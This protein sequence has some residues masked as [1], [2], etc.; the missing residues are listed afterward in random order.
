M[1]LLRPSLRLILGIFAA[2]TSLTA[3]SPAAEEPPNK[4]TITVRAVRPD[5]E[6][7]AV[8]HLFRGSRAANP[9]AALTAWKRASVE[10]KRLGKVVDAVIALLNPRMLREY[11]VLD[12]AEVAISFIPGSTRWDWR[13]RFPHDDGTLGVVGPTADLSGGRIEPAIGEYRVDRFPG[14]TLVLLARGPAGLFAAG[15]REQLEAALAVA[16]VP[17]TTPPVDS[18]WLIQIDPTARDTW[19]SLTGQR[20]A[21]AAQ[22]TGCQGVSGQVQ[23]LPTTLVATLTGQFA[24]N[25]PIVPSIDSAWLDPIPTRGPLAAFSLRVDPSAGA[26]SRV[27][28]L[29]DR[30]ERIDPERA[31]VASSRIRLALAAR[32][33]G[34]RLEA[35]VWPHLQGVSGWVGVAAGRLDRAVLVIHLDDPAAARRVLDGVKGNRRPDGPDEVVD[36]GSI[37][38]QP[39]RL[40]RRQATVFLAWG[41]RAW[42]ESRAAVDD[43]ARSARPWLIRSRTGALPS[44]VGAVWLDQLPRVPPGTPLAASLLDAPPIRWAG[45]NDGNRTIDEFWA[46]GLD[47]TVRRFLDRLP[48]DPAPEP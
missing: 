34:V 42:P 28:D 48:L 4:P 14:N 8:I 5:R 38:G 35:D 15:S 44:R 32:A 31:Q 25:T 1:S 10:P 39:L 19:T 37:A 16:S 47:A 9:A 24:G 46:D 41:D 29:L 18:G 23:F 7:E 6:V 43:P 22:T 30:V 13:A 27:F 45:T 2:I 21:A 40:I 17:A 3:P 11:Q 26:W 33:V 36:A 12:G 20:W